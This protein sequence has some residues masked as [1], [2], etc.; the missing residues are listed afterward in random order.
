[1]ERSLHS[2]STWN[3]MEN[4]TFCHYLIEAI[5]ASVTNLTIIASDYDWRQ[6][7]IW[8]N[9]AILLTHWGRVT[10]LYTLLI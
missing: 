3:W 10:H 5:Y 6:A 1:M 8:T 9:A 2:V 7:I 4:P